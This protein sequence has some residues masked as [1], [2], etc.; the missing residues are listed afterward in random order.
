MLIE[1]SVEDRLSVC[2]PFCFLFRAGTRLLLGWQPVVVFGVG[3]WGPWET[4]APVSALPGWGTDKQIS[5]AVPRPVRT[6]C[7]PKDIGSPPCALPIKT[8]DSVAAHIIHADADRRSHHLDSHTHTADSSTRRRPPRSRLPCTRGTP[9]RNGRAPD[10]WPLKS[11]NCPW[12]TGTAGPGTQWYGSTDNRRKRQSAEPRADVP[13]RV[14]PP[15]VAPGR[16]CPGSGAAGCS[17]PLT[18]T[19]QRRPGSGN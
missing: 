7:R 1:G 9:D 4:M 16:T 2:V 8:N 10:S 13:L 6:R 5:V 19:R 18:T 15:A 12:R 17:K 3:K 14:P 11:G